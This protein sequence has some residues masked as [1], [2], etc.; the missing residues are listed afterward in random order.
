[1]TKKNISLFVIL[2]LLTRGYCF[3]G[4]WL[5][6][7]AVSFLPYWL[8]G[9]VA[10]SAFLTLRTLFEAW[11]QNAYSLILFFFALRSWALTFNV[12]GEFTNFYDVEIH[13]GTIRE[14]AEEFLVKNLNEQPWLKVY[15]ANIYYENDNYEI[16]KRSIEKTDPDVVAL[17]EFSDDH[18]A[19]LKD[20]FQRKYPY[21]SA[22]SRSKIHAGNIIFSKYPIVN[23]LEK[24]DQNETPRRY[25]YVKIESEIPLYI[26][27][28]HTSAP[29]SSFLFLN[30]N[31]QLEAFTTDFKRQK[32]DRPL[33][34]NVLVLWDFNL[35]PWS[36]YYFLFTQE[37]WKD[38]K[39][40]FKWKKSV[41]TR[42]FKGQKI[43]N[44]H[45][46]HG[47]IN[48]WLEIEDLTVSDLIGS[49]HNQITFKIVEP[50]MHD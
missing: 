44:S 42:S 24:D 8:V 33:L 11:R 6:E 7:L 49:D 12:Y 32:I 36:D 20:Y 50:K 34:S 2:A 35:S 16:I 14:Q 3:R 15:Y 1:M 37:L 26:Y 17:V 27:L 28:V 23:E 38:M 30:R 21:T 25:N 31:I 46:D 10:F 18:E 4:A 22:T 40:I 45:I 39:N 43:L 47:F 5:T 13:R 19:K 41:F 48:N 29:V 9:L